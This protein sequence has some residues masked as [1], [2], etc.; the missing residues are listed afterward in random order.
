MDE[1]TGRHKTFSEAQI[2]LIKRKMPFLLL[3]EVQDHIS[4]AQVPISEEQVPLS[5]EQVPPSKAQ[6]SPSEAQ[7]PPS[8][9]HVPHSDSEVSICYE[10]L[11][12]NIIYAHFCRTV[13]IYVF[14]RH[15]WSKM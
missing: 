10:L 15:I 2:W 7:V 1:R 5:E 3:S 9:A 12:R 8:E 14:L 13:L 4:E 6:V 11:S